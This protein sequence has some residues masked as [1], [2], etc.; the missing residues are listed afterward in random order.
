MRT[1][2][3]TIG[4]YKFEELSDEAK[5]VAR[6]WYRE[7]VATD[8]DPEFILDDAVE[9]AKL[10]GIEFKTKPVQLYGGGYRYCPQIHWSGFHNQGD[11]AS[12]TATYSAVVDAERAIKAHAS[13]DDELHTIAIALDAIQKEYRHTVRASV[14]NNR[15]HYY[16]SGCMYAEYVVYDSDD[17]GG[18][19]D[20][21]SELEE[22]VLQIMRQ[23]ADWIYDQLRKQYEYEMSNESVDESIIANEYEFT[24]DGERF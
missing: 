11:G 4:L 12:F 21:E 15:G 10:L 7:G 19:Q 22:N 2:T 14:A 20:T 17:D 16:H 1:V 24:E 18:E 13:Q 3:T 5:E 8:F 6:Q 23:F 9:V